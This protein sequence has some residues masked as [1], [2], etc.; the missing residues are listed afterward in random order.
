MRDA[1]FEGVL[2]VHEATARAAAPDGDGDGP[3]GL[4][5]GHPMVL[6]KA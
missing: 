5:D 3:A 2:S 4:D 6:V 1:E